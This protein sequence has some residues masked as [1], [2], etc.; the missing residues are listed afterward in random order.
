M[1]VTRS[2]ETPRV[3]VT[4]MGMVTPLGVTVEDTWASA[5]AGKSCS[6]LITRFDTTGF[7][8]KVACEINDFDPSLYMG[9]REVRR[10]DRLVQMS[11]AA[12][13]QATEQAG[14][15]VTPDNAWRIG[16]LIGT[17]IGG[18][19]TIHEAYQAL[20]DKGP[21][22]VN[23]LTGAMMLPD[24][25]AGQV[26]IVLGVHGPNFGL[27]SACATG[28]HALGEA[29]EILRRGDADVMVAGAAEA[30]L[31]PFG[32][33]AFHRTGA[34]SMNS[35][36]PE[37][38]SRPFD[39][40]RD[41]FV[42]GE[43][44]ALMVLE[45]LDHALSRGAEPMIEMAGYGATADAFHVSAPLE[46][47]S[48]AARAMRI[49]MAKA[50][51]SADEIDYI[52][53]HGTATQLNDVAETRAIKLALGDRAYEVPVSSTKSMHGHMLGASGAVEAAL[54][55]LAMMTGM[56]PPTINYEFPDPEC[57]LDYVPNNARDVGGPLRVAMSNSFGFG[58]HNASL[59]FRRYDAGR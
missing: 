3:V 6:R 48:G 59:L 50:G 9:Y 52:N 34:M 32:L 37:R 2:T 54:T 55:T 51:V 26:S 14:L 58:G 20:A 56:L 11:V 5:L 40:L 22:R 53:A 24:M 44:A 57:D 10:F 38:A 46:D 36:E 23:P 42:F 25:P 43:G 12:A 8:V 4:G 15:V 47:G 45:T 1:V 16:V 17:G 19:E 18:L 30:G 28:A 27:S 33:A 13:Y 31:T 49:A 29:F 7:K 39:K 21:M 41:G 35:D